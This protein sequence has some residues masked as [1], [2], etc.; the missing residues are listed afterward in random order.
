MPLE[1]SGGLPKGLKKNNKYNET[2]AR[3]PFEKCKIF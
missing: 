3:E 1:A 2:F